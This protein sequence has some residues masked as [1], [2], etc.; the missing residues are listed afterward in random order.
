MSR[1]PEACSGSLGL[2]SI[3]VSTMKGSFRRRQRHLLPEEEP[4][5]NPARPWVS[6]FC[7]PEKL[8]LL[9]RRPGEPSPFRRVW[10]PSWEGCLG[11]RCN[12]NELGAGVE[13]L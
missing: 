12:G 5:A 3:S 7:L 8:S 13:E 10:Q 1:D 11:A 6:L 9:L 4:S 2:V